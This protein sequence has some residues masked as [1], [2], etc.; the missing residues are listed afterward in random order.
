[1]R[2][3]LELSAL[4]D[5]AVVAR[6]GTEIDEDTL[7]RVRALAAAIGAARAPG[8]VEVV[9][10]Y[11][12]V[13]VVYDPVQFAGAGARPLQTV[14][15][16]IAWCAE[17]CAEESSAGSDRRE[18]G[19]GGAGGGGGGGGAAVLGREPGAV[20]VLPVCYG[21][22]FGPDLATVAAHCG[23]SGADVIALHSGASYRVYAIGFVPGFPYL[24]G[25]PAALG[26]P[27]RATP[28]IRVPAGSV[29]IGGAQTGVYPLATPGGWHL[30][31]RTPVELFRPHEGR[32]CRLGMGDRV[33]F[34]AISPEEFA[35]W[36]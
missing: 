23:L 19:S 27:R 3:A 28:R 22:E 9:P 4:G 31:G 33:Q 35:A 13:T 30:I 20:H 21:G 18:G 10:A 11:A 25:L 14:S 16:L 8:V 5:S 29:G 2:P 26:V 24:G 36:R 7:E 17:R 6:L 34:Q 1:M 15:Q 32:P 12:T